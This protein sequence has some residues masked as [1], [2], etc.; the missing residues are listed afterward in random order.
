MVGIYKI[1]SPSGKVYIGQSRDIERRFRN[2]KNLRCKNQKKLYASLKKYGVDN[3]IFEIMCELLENSSQEELNSKEIEWWKF[4]IDNGFEVMNIKEPGSNGRLSKETI[5]KI[6]KIHIGRKLSDESKEKIRN[7]LL[8]KKHSPERCEKM[9]K[10]LIGKTLGISKP[11]SEETKEKISKTLKGKKMPEE[12]KQKIKEHYNKP[13]VREKIRETQLGKKL[14]EDS[15]KK[16]SIAG[17]GRPKP[18]VTCPHCGKI[19][20]VSPMSQYHFDNCKNKK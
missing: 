15:K 6:R 4:Y 9:S 1:T 7:S 3:H 14:S 12:I 17:K 11:M 8:G 2:Y 18:K 10:S 19:G 16:L 13:G 20:G 5:E